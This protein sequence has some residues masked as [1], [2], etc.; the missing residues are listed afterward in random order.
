MQPVTFDR[1]SGEARQKQ[2]EAA[3]S[4][5][6]A[7]PEKSQQPLVFCIVE[8]LTWPIDLG[9][10]PVYGGATSRTWRGAALLRSTNVVNAYTQGIRT[11][12]AH[13]RGFAENRR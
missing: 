12:R 2:G 5:L 9:L 11:A 13:V 1:V 4:A 6:G 10:G 3:V 8:F 7:D